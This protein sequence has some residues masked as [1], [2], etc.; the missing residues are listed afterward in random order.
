MEPT[1]LE[2]YWCFPLSHERMSNGR[3]SKIKHVLSATHS[4]FTP[5]HTST[6][7]STLQHQ[8]SYDARARLWVREADKPKERCGGGQEKKKGSS[9][10]SHDRNRAQ[11][12][13]R[14]A[15]GWKVG[16]R[17]GKGGGEAGGDMK[18]E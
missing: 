18:S 15:E 1:L 6:H 16:W 5:Q 3:G 13:G 10:N 12:G 7:L 17:R 8:V 14:G 2:K 4:Q 9:G 11:R